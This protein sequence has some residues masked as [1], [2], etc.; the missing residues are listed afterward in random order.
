MLLLHCPA[1]QVPH[2]AAAAF[3]DFAAADTA[4]A[5]G[6]S[7]AADTQAG[8]CKQDFINVRAEGGSKRKILLSP[9]QD[10]DADASLAAMRVAC[11]QTEAAAN[12]F[13]ILRRFG[14]EAIPAYIP[15]GSDE[16]PS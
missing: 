7:A 3:G 2:T 9:H 12:L 1:V 5:F 6:D 15:L 11:L 4:A 13:I 16:P 8:F 10:Y 14:L